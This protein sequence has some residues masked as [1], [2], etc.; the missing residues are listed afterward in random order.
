[1]PVGEVRLQ[2]EACAAR[3]VVVI[4]RPSGAVSC[5]RSVK[6]FSS[7]ARWFA[8]ATSIPH[9]SFMMLWIT[10]DGWFQSRSTSAR[11]VST[12]RWAASAVQ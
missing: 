2:V 10:M 7:H 5:L 11:K 9:C 4:N 6:V 8:W 1:M 12:P 3:T